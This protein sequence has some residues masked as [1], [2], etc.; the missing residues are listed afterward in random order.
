M[1]SPIIDVISL[2]NFAYLAA[3]ADLRGGGSC[4][5]ERASR[6]E[7]RQRA[8]AGKSP[9]SRALLS[10]ALPILSP[11]PPSA[12]KR[13]DKESPGL[14]VPHTVRGGASWSFFIPFPHHG[15]IAPGTAGAERLAKGPGGVFWRA[16]VVWT[17]RTGACGLA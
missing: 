9:G 13:R 3:S 8:E 11:P 6:L 4:S 12:P 1:V 17:G 10:L 5:S 15:H 16:D 7:K 2:D 14:E